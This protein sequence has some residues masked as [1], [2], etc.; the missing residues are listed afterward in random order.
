MKSTE[1]LI[2]DLKKYPIFEYEEHILE[3]ESHII[4]CDILVDKCIKRSHFLKAMDIDPTNGYKYLNGSRNINRDLFL[5]MLVVCGCDFEEI[6]NSL[7]IASFAP[8]YPKVLRDKVIMHQI[9]F[10]ANLKEINKA[11]AEKDLNLL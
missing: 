5:K 1:S 10:K 9:L 7:K 3:Q 8:L 4:I 2:S 11:L 6:Q